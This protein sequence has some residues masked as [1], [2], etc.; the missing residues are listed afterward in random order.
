MGKFLSDNGAT[1]VALLIVAGLFFLAVRSMVRKK[2]RTGS[3]FSCGGD[4]SSCAY[5]SSCRKKK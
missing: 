5:H 1:I 4:C 3:V 2:R